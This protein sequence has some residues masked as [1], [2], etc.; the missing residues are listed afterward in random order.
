MYL[1]GYNLNRHKRRG[2]RRV[3]HLSHGKGEDSFA[4]VSTAFFWAG[5]GLS[6]S[7]SP[8]E[9][10]TVLGSGTVPGQG[11]TGD[12][13]GFHPQIP[14]ILSAG[15]RLHSLRPLLPCSVVSICSKVTRMVSLSPPTA[16]NRKGFFSSWSA[17]SLAISFPGLWKADSST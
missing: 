12:I 15:S 8:G 7:V 10:V 9:R 14:S 4:P 11:Q 3:D 2:N 16:T 13:G 5:V 1:S 17:R 6:C